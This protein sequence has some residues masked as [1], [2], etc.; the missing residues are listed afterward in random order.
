ML[1]EYSSRLRQA[2][3]HAD[4]NQKEL[5]ARTGIKQSSVS[6]AMTRAT[7]STDNARYADAC[8]VNP[9]WLETGEGEMLGAEPK[10]PLWDQDA[11]QVAIMVMGIP[12]THRAQA[13]RAAIKTLIEC[14]QTA[15]SQPLAPVDAEAPRNE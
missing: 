11:I 2:M 3:A 12:A 7:G 9:R 6:S 8:G 5:I 15:Q 10:P 13:A 14:F 1:T 4:I